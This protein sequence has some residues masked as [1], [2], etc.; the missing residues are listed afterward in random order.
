MQRSRVEPDTC[1]RGKAFCLEDGDVE[2][3]GLQIDASQS[4][5]S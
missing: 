3:V 2:A 1:W 4:V 5:A